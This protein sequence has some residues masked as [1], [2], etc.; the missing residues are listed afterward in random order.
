[1]QDT[2][3]I[4]GNCKKEMELCGTDDLFRINDVSIKRKNYKCMNCTGT[5]VTITTITRINE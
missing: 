1:M 3:P 5:F 2:K 4:C